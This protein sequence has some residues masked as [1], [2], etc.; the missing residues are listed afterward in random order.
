MGANPGQVITRDAVQTGEAVL[1][2]PQGK[3]SNHD[4]LVML[5]RLDQSGYEPPTRLE[6]TAEGF[7]AYSAICTHLACTVRF[8]GEGVAAA[9]FSH[10]HCPCHAGVFDPRHGG[11]VVAGP[12]PRALP[13]LAVRLNQAG[14]V[15]AAGKFEEPIGVVV[16]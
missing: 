16:A 14:E 9:P 7:A 6:W 3:E 8:S 4:N 2:F 15:I 12:P 11:A 5:V 13:Q 10:I 1:A